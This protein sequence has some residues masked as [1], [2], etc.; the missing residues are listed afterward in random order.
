MSKPHEVKCLP[1]Y[2]QA[3]KRGDKTFEIRY[4]DR[5]YQVG[6]TLIICEWDNDRQQFTGDRVTRTISYMTDF[7]QGPGF[8]VLG[9]R[10]IPSPAEE[11]YREAMQKAIKVLDMP[12]SSVKIEAQRILYQALSPSGEQKED[13][14]WKRFDPE[15]P[16][17]VD[18]SYLATDGQ[19]IDIA[20]FQGLF[21]NEP[22]R[23]YP[24]DMSSIH[25]ESITHYMPLPAM[26]KKEDGE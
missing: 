4:N 11:R 24:P 2:F 16:P 15:S 10:S 19:N 3:V 1:E 26:P 21:D 7:E 13:S 14:G 22:P 8:V 6:D 25:H 5:D 18:N 12:V 17:D 23:L 9:L 20:Y